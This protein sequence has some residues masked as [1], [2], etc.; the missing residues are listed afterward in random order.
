M[1]RKSASQQTTV[2]R[3]GRKVERRMRSAGAR[4][5]RNEEW[6]PRVTVARDLNLAVDDFGLR[7][8]ERGHGNWGQRH[9]RGNRGAGLDFAVRQRARSG[10]GHS[11]REL[12]SALKHIM[13][14]P[15][16]PHAR[17]KV[18]IEVAME[19]RV[20]YDFVSIAAAVVSHLER[21]A[22]A[23][24]NHL[25]IEIAALVALGRLQ[26]LVRVLGMH[27]SH[28]GPPMKSSELHL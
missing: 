20:A 14:A 19:N 26:P 22:R 28:P 5:T 12:R 1:A 9:D 24:T 27:V 11:V 18:R 21:V 4:E 8:R 23:R 10:D 25:T 17:G 15:H 3:V 6:K 13:R 16:R 7:L 2:H